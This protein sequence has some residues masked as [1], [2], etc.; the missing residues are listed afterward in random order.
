MTLESWNDENTRN[1]LSLLVGEAMLQADGE[2][3][4]GH[5]GRRVGP[6]TGLAVAVTLHKPES[7]N[8]FLVQCLE[9]GSALVCN[10]DSGEGL[11]Q[12]LADL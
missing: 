1:L 10:K 3:H 9:I 8:C 6:P 4:Q 11:G 12:S 7:N 5:Q 2:A